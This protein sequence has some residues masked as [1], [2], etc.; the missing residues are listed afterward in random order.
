MLR[1]RKEGYYYCTN[2]HN[3]T[4]THTSHHL[5]TQTHTQGYYSMSNVF[6][7]YN[8]NMILHVSLYSDCSL[9]MFC[10]ENTFLLSHFLKR[11]VTS[12]TALVCCVNKDGPGKQITE[13]LLFLLSFNLGVTNLATSWYCS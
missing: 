8:W 1:K 10:L 11:N 3:I 12:L 4:N 13:L 9:R 7:S 5:R 2:V 6:T